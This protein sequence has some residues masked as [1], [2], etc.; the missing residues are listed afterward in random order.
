MMSPQP[1]ESIQANSTPSPSLKL[2]T[3]LPDPSEYRRAKRR[4]QNRESA[5]RS[6]ARREVKD[7]SLGREV[8]RLTAANEDAQEQIRQLRELIEMMKQ[9]MDGYRCWLAT[10]AKH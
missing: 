8:I 9:E 10:R 1:S 4:R 7:Q 6:R 3:V 2:E 5:V